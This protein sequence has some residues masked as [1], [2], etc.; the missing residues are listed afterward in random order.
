MSFMFH[1]ASS[2][3]QELESWNTSKVTDM[4]AMFYGA[5]AFNQE[6]GS[7][8]TSNVTNMSNMFSGQLRFVKTLALGMSLV[9]S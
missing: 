7:W 5:T 6:I 2:F 4:R 1:E 9:L 3:N 8:D